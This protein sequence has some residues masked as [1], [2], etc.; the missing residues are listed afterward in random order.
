MGEQPNTCIQINYYERRELLPLLIHGA[1]GH[2]K[3]LLDVLLK[4]RRHIIGIVTPHLD[5]GTNYLGLSVIGNDE[6][7]F[8][9]DTQEVLLINGIGS[10]PGKQQRWNLSMMMRER[11]YR[12]SRVIHPNSTIATDVLLAEG[13]QI[14][15]GVIIQPGCKIGQDSIINTGSQIDHDVIIGDNC[16]IAPGVT[17]S[18]EVKIGDNV[19]IGTGAKVIQ[20]L[21]IGAGSVIAAGTTVYKDVPSGVKVHQQARIV[22]EEFKD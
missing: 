22:M 6:S 18:G 16:H 11:G 7:V 5:S 3:V 12:F 4:E 14:M 15:A 13:V 2:T 19:H 17:I 10:L 21:T 1:G 8:K 20:R 9:Y